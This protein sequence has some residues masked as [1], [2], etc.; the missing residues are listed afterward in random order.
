MTDSHTHTQIMCMNYLLVIGYHHAIRVCQ[1]LVKLD[2]PT[3]C[4]EVSHHTIH[5]YVAMVTDYIKSAYYRNP[6]TYTPR[7]HAYLH[8]WGLCGVGGRGS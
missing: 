2:P 8:R 6:L 7:L 1:V 3:P 5:I 4:H